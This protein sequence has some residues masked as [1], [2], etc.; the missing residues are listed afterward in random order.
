MRLSQFTET[1]PNRWEQAPAKGKAAPVVIFASPRLLAN[2]DE[3]VGRQLAGVAGLPGL[4]GP[5]MALPDAH[6][7][8]GFPIG[9]VAAFDPDAE[10]VVC[11]GGVGFDIACGVRTL[12]TGLHEE[13]ILAVQQ[14]LADALFSAVPSG[15]GSTGDVRLTGKDMDAMLTGGALWA[16]KRGHGTAT[17]LEYIEEGGRM[18]GADPKAVSEHAKKR[19]RNEAGTL[20]SGNH[21]LEIQAVD[22]I[23]D[24]RAAD[25]FGLRPGEVLVSVHCGS[26]GL[27]HQIGK[28]FMARMLAEAPRHGLRLNDKELA[29]APAHS[30][31]GREYLA[32][33]RAGINCA[34]AN[35]QIIADL[36]RKTFASVLPAARL[37]LIY[38]VSHNTCKEETH[39]VGKG[40]RRLLVHRKG[41]TRALAPGHPALPPAYAAVGQPAFIGGSMG[42]PSFILTGTAEGEALSYASVCHG[43]GRAMSRTQAKKSWNGGPVLETLRKR[44]I[45]VRTASYKGAAEEAPGAY[46]DIEAVIEATVDAGLATKVARVRP[47]VCV[48][49]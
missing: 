33:M 9:G 38:D 11:A 30:A 24:A 12:R 45:L 27:G 26:R 18:D 15:V 2:M 32:A 34:L 6:Q 16:V 41:A 44:G 22:K 37:S 46:K 5:A 19:M 43:A 21:Y 23:Y 28:D 8:Y 1:G 35:R 48:K 42:A 36:V 10:G 13:D 4:V 40:K 7:G 3:T 20:G 29:C 49:G 25:A 39:H 14:Q 47:M 31:L 17:D